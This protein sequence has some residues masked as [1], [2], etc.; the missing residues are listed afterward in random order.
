MRFRE[1]VSIFVVAEEF[2]DREDRQEDE[3]EYDEIDVDVPTDV[4]DF[5]RIR[6]GG[7]CDFDPVRFFFSVREV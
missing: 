7:V 3:D 2:E 6:L 1:H 4:P 5:V